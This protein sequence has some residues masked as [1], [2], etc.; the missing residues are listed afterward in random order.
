MNTGFF[1]P[2]LHNRS[3]CALLQK[4]GLKKYDEEAAYHYHTNKYR[5]CWPHCDVTLFATSVLKLRSLVGKV[6]SGI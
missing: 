1:I 6:H 5:S 2:V 4:G 3:V